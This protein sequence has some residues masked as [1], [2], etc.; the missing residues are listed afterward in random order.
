L[1]NRLDTSALPAIDA[2]NFA[3]ARDGAQV[4]LTSD[5]RDPLL[6]K[7]QMGLGRVV[8]WLGDDGSDF[9]SGWSTWAE[10]DAFWGNTLRWSLPDPENKSV[11]ASLTTDGRDA[12]VTLDA[13]TADG[14][15]IDLSGGRATL[16]GPDGAAVS[17]PLVAAG[18]GI[19]Q[20]RM[21]EPLPGAWQLTLEDS[22]TAAGTQMAITIPPSREY[23]PDP[24]ATG[25]MQ[26]IVSRTDGTLL[27][28]DAPAPAN[29]FNIT[30]NSGDRRPVAG[31]QVWH[32]P[33]IAALLLFLFDIALRLGFLQDV[34]SR[35][36]R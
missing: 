1:L 11:T 32:W 19:W 27:S 22:A 23:F 29:L 35:L 28:L 33:V 24:A 26:E 4:D 15:E 6:V 14:E 10:Y 34:R 30:A 7:W 13:L 16:T 18:S 5:R 36:R 2:Y 21:T 12:V 25:L 8:S 31:R 20:V 3:A 17:L 9:A